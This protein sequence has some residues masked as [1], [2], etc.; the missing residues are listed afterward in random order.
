M[1]NREKLKC[2]VLGT[3][4]NEVNEER[5]ALITE[6]IVDM[7]MSTELYNSEATIVEDTYLKLILGILLQENIDTKR[8]T[9]LSGKIARFHIKNNYEGDKNS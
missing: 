2:Y 1:A 3:I 6:K 5:R 7:V 8:A 4:Y 9:A